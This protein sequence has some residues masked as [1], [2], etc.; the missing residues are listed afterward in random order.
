[1]ISHQILPEWSGECRW[2]CISSVSKLP[3]GSQK[4]LFQSEIPYWTDT[5]P[6]GFLIFGE[7]QKGPD[8]DFLSL[9]QKTLNVLWR[10]G[11]KV[12]K[13]IG[14]V[15]TYS[16]DS[17]VVV[18]DVVP[19]RQSSSEEWPSLAGMAS[20]LESW[21]FNVIWKVE[22]VSTCTVSPYSLLLSG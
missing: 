22:Q 12:R 18:L 6:K 13:G 17:Y 15:V 8:V 20:G 19:S 7:F 9:L 21:R 2:T 4:F 5:F 11:P 10:L 16:S 3:F 1:M 14:R